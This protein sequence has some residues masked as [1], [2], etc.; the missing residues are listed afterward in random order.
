MVY[1]TWH[2]I[3]FH[4][5]Q[6]CT[7]Q[8]LRVN[9]WTVL[10]LLC[11]VMVKYWP[12]YPYEIFTDYIIET[13]AIVPMSGPAKK[14]K[15]MWVTGSGVGVTKVPFVKFSV[16]K[17]FVLSKVPLRL[18]E[19]HS[20]LTDATAAKLRRHLPNINVIFKANMCFDNAGKFG[21]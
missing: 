16:S 5:P 11:F 17:N 21:K 2:N 15:S 12:I 8:P 14:S 10:C 4:S 6:N 18:F 13:A 20:Y 9:I 3:G 1:Q 19:S 7:V